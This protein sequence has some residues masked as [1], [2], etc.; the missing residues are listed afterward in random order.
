[1][2]RELHDGGASGIQDDTLGIDQ[3][4]PGDAAQL[5]DEGAATPAGSTSD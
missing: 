4:L 2:A 1:V 3:E 5:A